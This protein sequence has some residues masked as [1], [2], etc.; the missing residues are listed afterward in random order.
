MMDILKSITSDIKNAKHIVAFTGAGISA[1]SGIPTY[2][3]E[4]GLWTKYD[5]NLY[6]HIGYFR[7]NPSYY[8]NFFKDVRYPML[9]KVKP[10]KAHL[11][12]AEIES[13]GH[14]KTVITQN[15]DGLHQ[16]AG[17]SSVIELHGTTRIIHC[18]ECS[19]EY[20]MNDVF[21]K[22]EKQ[23]PPLC[24]KCNGILRPAVVFFGEM[25][26]PQTINQAYREAEKSDLILAV[27]SSLVVYPAA[28]IPLRAK[29][30]GAK[31]AIINRDSTPLDSMADYVINDAAGN[32]LP[33]VVENLKDV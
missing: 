7:Q 32:V 30:T 19:K 9:K 8:W 27:G 25:L 16:E 21:A 2:R 5:P 15:I 26:D 13:I 17:S 28:D 6:A 23:I 14:L 4:D 22:L 24:S 20:I 3:G 12:L 29:Q 1:E 33:I 10:N 11:A 31:L 18:M